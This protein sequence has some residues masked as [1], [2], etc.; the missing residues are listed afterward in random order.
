MSKAFGVIREWANAVEE[1]LRSQAALGSLFSHKGLIGETREN[2]LI[3]ILK[4]FLP[5]SA[6]I[7]TGQIIDKNRVHSRQIDIVISRG[8][9]FQFPLNES[10][11]CIYLFESVLAAIEVKTKFDLPTIID[12]LI[13]IE[14]VYKLGT[15]MSLSNPILNPIDANSVFPAGY[16]Y[17]FGSDREKNSPKEFRKF[18]LSALLKSKIRTYRAPAII[19]SNGWVALRNDRLVVPK[20]NFGDT[21][22]YAYRKEKFTLYWLIIHLISKF[23][24]TLGGIGNSAVKGNYHVD[25]HFDPFPQDGWD[26]LQ[27]PLK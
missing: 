26:I 1:S 16:I 8:D 23:N 5:S 4:R 17:S 10:G 9:S 7:G 22:L 6:N 18:L 14:S 19:G 3:D 25:M 2:Q 27:D 13:T 24:S 11:S 21:W 12:A 20:D 15:K